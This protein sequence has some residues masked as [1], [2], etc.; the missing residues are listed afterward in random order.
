MK[1]FKLIGAALLL[2]FGAITS[3]NSCNGND[4]GPD[5]LCSGIFSSESDCLDAIKGADN[6]VCEFENNKWVARKDI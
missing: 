3:F 2:G 1:K 6:C 4:P 5:G